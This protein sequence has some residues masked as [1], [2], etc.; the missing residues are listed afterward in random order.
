MP[1][2]K[3]ATAA[4]TAYPD[5]PIANALYVDSWTRVRTLKT[6]NLKVKQSGAPVYAYIFSRETP[7]LGGFAMAYHCAEI[8]FVFD[9]IELAAQATGATIEAYALADKISRAVNTT[10]EGAT[11]IFDNESA[12]RFRHDEKLMQLLAP[13]YT[14]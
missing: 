2:D 3:F 7:V 6:I 12:V 5:K 1:Y 4:N 9:N 14:R 8:P 11:M 13:D 10:S